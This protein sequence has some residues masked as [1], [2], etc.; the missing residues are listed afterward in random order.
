MEELTIPF[1]ANRFLGKHT[2]RIFNLLARD[3][4]FETT[5]VFARSLPVVEALLDHECLLSS[6]TAIE[7]NPGQASQP[8]HSDDGSYG[9]PRPAPTH[10]VVAMWA[11]TDFTE[12]NGG[13]HVVP[14]T[15]RA[16]S[17]PRKGDAPETVQVEMPAGSILFYD[18]SLW[19]GGGE[20][21]SDADRIG[22][23]ITYTLGWLR[24][25]ENQYLTCPPE[26]AKD[27]DQPLQELIGYSMGQY[28]LGY[29][30]PPGKP[31]EHPE[32]V[33]PQY[34]L[35]REIEGGMLGTSA[36]LEALQEDIS[37]Q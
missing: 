34:A 21:R 22:I 25:E 14:G 13:T 15:H 16:E 5:P 36:E 29:Y 28:A 32:I 24:Q 27:L 18:G 37:N 3:V 8:L 19:H 17:R 2:R 23:N 35:G 30:T 33:P 26:I 31:G 4:L 7:M 6:L 1:G 20:N 12:E 10:I 11:L 9:F